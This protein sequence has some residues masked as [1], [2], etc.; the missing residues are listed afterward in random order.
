MKEGKLTLELVNSKKLQEKA[1]KLKAVTWKDRPGNFCGPK[2]DK[3]T[4]YDLKLNKPTY[5][6]LL[7]KI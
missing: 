3:Y 4:Q 1:K 7:E 5:D 2:T 6:E